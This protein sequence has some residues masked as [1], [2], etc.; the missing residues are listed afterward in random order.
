MVGHAWFFCHVKATNKEEQKSEFKPALLCIKTDFAS[1]PA[2][3]GWVSYRLYFFYPQV[4]ENICLLWFI[5]VLWHIS[6]WRLFNAKSILYIKTVLFRTIQ[7]KISMQFSSF[8]LI[9]KSI[10]CNISTLFIY[11]NSSISNNSLK[12]CQVLICITNNAIRY[13]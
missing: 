12:W 5:L 7:F 2:F 10:H 3:S 1:K 9:F 11:Q 6:L 4:L 8:W 13:H